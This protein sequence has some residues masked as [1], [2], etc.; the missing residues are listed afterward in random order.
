MPIAIAIL[1][2]VVVALGAFVIF[3]LLRRAQGGVPEAAGSG[4]LAWR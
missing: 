2:F 4:A 3:S 1:V